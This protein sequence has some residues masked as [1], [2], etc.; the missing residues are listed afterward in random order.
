[1]RGKITVRPLAMRRSVVRIAVSKTPERGAR[2]RLR[3]MEAVTARRT[4]RLNIVLFL[5]LCACV[6]HE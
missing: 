3:D 5:A 6:G 4:A 2:L 1:M